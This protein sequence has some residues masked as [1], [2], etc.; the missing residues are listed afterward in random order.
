MSAQAESKP[1]FPLAAQVLIGLVLGVTTGLFFGEMV[2][3]LHIVGE[4]FIKLLRMTVIPYI[5]VSLIGS[6]GTPKPRGGQEPGP[7]GRCGSPR[8]VGNRHRSDFPCRTGLA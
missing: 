7:E 6:L 1:R 3:F 2:A 8:S 5:V 4:G